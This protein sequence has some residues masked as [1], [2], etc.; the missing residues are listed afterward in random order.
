MEPK[1]M[2][3]AFFLSIFFLLTACSVVPP[4]ALS[5]W[6][7]VGLTE[8]TIEDHVV[9][10]VSGKNCSTIRTNQGRTYCEEDEKNP[11]PKVHCYRT[12]GEVTCYDKPDPHA[13]GHQKVDEAEYNLLGRKNAER[14]I[15]Y[16]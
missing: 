11:E 12:I 7:T 3:Y 5:D 9:S 4:L 10:V 16:R 15:P 6:A 8:K 13:N 2:R 14:L 1:F